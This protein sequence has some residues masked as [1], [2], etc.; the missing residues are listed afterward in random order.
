MKIANPKNSQIAFRIDSGLYREVKKICRKRDISVT[1]FMT[2]AINKR[3]EP[4]REN[5]MQKSE[6]AKSVHVTK[7]YDL[8][9]PIGGNRNINRLHA[10]RLKKSMAEKYLFTVIIVNENYEIIDGQHRYTVIKEL[11]LP[12]Y[13]IILQGYGLNEVH[14][15]NQNSKVWSADDYVAG[16]SE[17]GNEN[18]IIYKRFIDKYKFGHG[19]SIAMLNG[20]ISKASRNRYQSFKEGLFKITHL[21]EAEEKAQKIWLLNGIY[22]GFRRRSFVIAILHLFNNEN[23]DYDEFLHKLK[24][25][26]SALTDCKDTRQYLELIEEIYNY[27]RREKVNL[28]Y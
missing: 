6:I 17:L 8:F 1:D 19:E 7:D 4:Q 24:K 14:T 22:E 3:V 13:Y 9:K 23:F 28:R 21:E 16:Y 10:S 11:G 20:L 26:P 27:R 15:L 2:N 5:Q 12:L 18:Y 25:Q